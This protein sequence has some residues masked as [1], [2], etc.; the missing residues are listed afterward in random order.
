MP[1]KRVHW[2]GFSFMFV[3]NR[4]QETKQNWGSSQ[5]FWNQ[6]FREHS[7]VGTAWVFVSLPKL[8]YQYHLE[9]APAPVHLKTNSMSYVDIV[10]IS[11]APARRF[12]TRKFQARHGTYSITADTK[13]T[14][15][16]VPVRT[17]LYS[18]FF[19]I[20]CVRPYF[21]SL[22]YTIYSPVKSDPGS[23][24]RLFLVPPTT[25]IASHFLSREDF[26]PFFPRRL[27]S[28]ILLLKCLNTHPSTDSQVP[29]VAWTE[30]LHLKQETIAAPG[31]SQ[32]RHVSHRW[33]WQ[34][35]IC[36]RR[37]PTCSFSMDSR[38]GR[39]TK[40]KVGDPKHLSGTWYILAD[41]GTVHDSK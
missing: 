7:N 20:H 32:D 25:V 28:I 18:S 35:Q 37:Q 13:N 14:H 9:R 26:S 6:L 23:H 12:A 36:T 27:A 31:A 15:T 1:V 39:C 34:S 33:S 16:H 29:S 11:F 10:A 3:G 22:S 4:P 24:S 21:L 2:V 17:L 19:P 40:R 8:S 5:F 38:I 30:V 41:T